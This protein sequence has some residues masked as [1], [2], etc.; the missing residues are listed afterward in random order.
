MSWK[1]IETGQK[2]ENGN[3]AKSES[4]LTELEHKIENEEKTK[5][6]KRIIKINDRFELGDESKKK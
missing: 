4:K 6:N 2:Y 1:Q 3:S 5:L